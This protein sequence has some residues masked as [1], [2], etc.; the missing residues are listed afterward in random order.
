MTS[1]ATIPDSARRV[2]RSPACAAAELGATACTTAPR[3]TRSCRAT[4]SDAT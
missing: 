4:V 2:G 3:V 1:P